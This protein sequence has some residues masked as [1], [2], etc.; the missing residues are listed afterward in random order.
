MGLLVP[1]D[2]DLRTIENGDEREV[3]SRLVDGLTDGWLIFPNVT[4]QSDR[5]HEIDVV[6]LHEGQ[7][8]VHLE[9]KGIAC[10]CRLVNG[11]A[12]RER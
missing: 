6:L 3:V 4:F 1:A 5:H 8:V 9:V 7:G 12:F 2:F 11:L 10:T